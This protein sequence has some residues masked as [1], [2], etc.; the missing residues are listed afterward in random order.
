METKTLLPL[1]LLSEGEK[2]TVAKL[3]GGRIFQEKMISMGITQG[4]VVEVL[5]G[6][7]GQALL[8]LIGNTRLAL[9]FGL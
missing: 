3:N 1:S 6:T 5:T 8:V 9:G 4:D 2:G 7:P